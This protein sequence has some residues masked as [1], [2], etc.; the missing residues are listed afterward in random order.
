MSMRHKNAPIPFAANAYQVGDAGEGNDPTDYDGDADTC[1]KGQKHSYKSHQDHD[2][3]PSDGYT[4]CVL[5]CA[6]WVHDALFVHV[7]APFAP[8][9]LTIK[10]FFIRMS[11]RLMPIKDHFA[12][13]DLPLH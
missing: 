6:Q 5:E 10:P 1:R 3:G 12:V 7:F 13:G 9:R 4:G 2:D 8:L 11:A